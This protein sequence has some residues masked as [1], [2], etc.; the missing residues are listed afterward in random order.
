MR[1]GVCRSFIT[2]GAV[3]AMMV[4]AAPSAHGQGCQNPPEPTLDCPGDSCNPERT[5]C[6]EAGFRITLTGYD[7]APSSMTGGGTY[8]YQICS[9]PAGTCV[10]TVR[11]GESCLDNSFCQKKGQQTDPAAYCTRDCT[12]KSPSDTTCNSGEFRSLSHFDI[13]FPSLDPG[14]CLDPNNFVG[15]TCAC[16]GGFPGCSVNPTVTLGDGSCY[17]SNSTIAKCD[18]TTLPVGACIEMSVT[19]SGETNVVGLGRSVVIDKEAN[20]CTE[21]CLA[22]PVC[23]P[24]EDCFNQVDDDCDGFTDCEDPDCA[25]ECVGGGEC[26]TRTLGFWGTHPWITN[27]YTPVTVCG[28]SVGCDGADDGESNPSCESGHCDDVMEALGSNSSEIKN[29]SAYI[30]LLKQLAAA[31]LNL[32]AT[33]SLIEGA[34]CSGFQYAGKTIQAWIEACEAQNLC[35]GSQSK[36]SGSGC[37]EALNAFNNSPDVGFDTPPPPFE[38]PPLDDHGNISGA[39]P[40][41]FTAAGGTGIIIGKRQCAGQ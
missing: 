32:E 16:V 31:K 30:A 36:I 11:Q 3:V 25:D 37:I 29:T 8:T 33:A 34:S 28:H 13:D 18:N 24:P 35:N 15:G 10:S 19:I 14:S 9:P 26:L 40:S 21:T 41:N 23:V 22:G 5:T 2:V 20:Q 27:N 6:T 1:N 39:D 17:C 12:C 7:P 4:L 38:R